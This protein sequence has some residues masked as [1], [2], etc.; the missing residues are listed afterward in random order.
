MAKPKRGVKWESVGLW[1]KAGQLSIYRH[2][3]RQKHVQEEL[4]GLAVCVRRIVQEII[5]GVPKPGLSEH[6]KRSTCHPA[7]D[8]QLFC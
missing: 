5:K 7:V 6:L 3:T 8:V 4:E 1:A 2:K